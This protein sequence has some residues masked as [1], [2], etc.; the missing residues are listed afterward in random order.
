MAQIVWKQTNHR[1]G[2]HI[3]NAG[4]SVPCLDHAPSPMV[5]SAPRRG[6]FGSAQDLAVDGEPAE[7]IAQDLY[8]GARPAGHA[9]VPVVESERR[10]DVLGEVAG[11]GGDVA[12]QGEVLQGG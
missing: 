9:D 10:G 6:E 3:G 11:G 7:N 1:Q 8:S 5:F 2:V 4:G 12:G